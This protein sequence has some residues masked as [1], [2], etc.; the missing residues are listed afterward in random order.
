MIFNQWK[1]R[2]S[3]VQWGGLTILYKVIWVRDVP[4]DTVQ[5]DEIENVTVLDKD[6]EE[7]RGYYQDHCKEIDELIL[8][9]AQK[10]IP[11]D[12][13]TPSWS[14]IQESRAEQERD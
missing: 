8:E 13:E 11:D 9:D 5:L 7:V 3:E 4:R 10:T 2:E 12:W 14:E 6:G 1:T